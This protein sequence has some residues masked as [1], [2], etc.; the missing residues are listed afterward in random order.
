MDKKIID[1]G[2]VKIAVIHSETPIIT[3]ARD[4]LDLM[5]TIDY[6]DGSER[7]ALNKEAFAEDFFRLSSGMAGEILQKFANYSKKLAIIGDFSAYTSKPLRDFIYE[8]NEG[9]SVF[10]VKDESEAVERLG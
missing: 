8:C 5:A 6:E 9:N 4:A 3:E 7:I 2:S 1:I 10:F